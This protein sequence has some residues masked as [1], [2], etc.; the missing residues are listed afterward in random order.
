MSKIVTQSNSK[1]GIKSEFLFS[2]GII[3][4]EEFRVGIKKG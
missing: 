1:I 4:S 2:S 3:P